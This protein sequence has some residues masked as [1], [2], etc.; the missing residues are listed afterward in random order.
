VL[1]DVIDFSWTLFLDR[2]GVINHRVLD[3]YVQKIEDF[4]FNPGVLDF[5]KFA[6]LHF[7]KI[8]VVTN[9]Q[10]V[11]KGLMSMEDLV[12]IHN[13]MLNTVIKHNGRI[14]K[15]YVATNLKDSVDNIRKPLPFMGYQA[16]QDFPTIDFSKS[17]M[18]GDTNSDLLFGKN[19]GMKTILVETIENISVGYDYKISHLSELIF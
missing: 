17:I 1:K 18:I 13:Y 4:H 11:G 16:K 12:S 14:D 9:Q 6:H 7:H 8:V 3:G 19:L 10:G 5:L 15:I 2:D